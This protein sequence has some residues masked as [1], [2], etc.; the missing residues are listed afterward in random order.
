MLKKITLQVSIFVLLFCTFCK[1][2][3]QSY[4]FAEIGDQVTAYNNAGEFDQTIILL[5]GIIVDRKATAYDRYMAYYL[6]YQTYKRLFVYDKAELNLNLALEEGVKSERKNKVAAQI[7]FEK[8]FMNFDLLKFVEVEQLLL[9]IEEKDFEY[10]SYSTQ[11]FY[12]AVL[13]IMAINKGQLE[14][15]AKNYEIAIHLFETHEPE[16]LPM[17]YRKQIDLYR[18][19]NQHDKA[20]ESFEKGLYYA[21]KYNI[22]VYILNMYFDL[23]HYYKLTGD[24]EKGIQAQEM[25]DKLAKAY[26]ESEVLG[27]LNILESQLMQERIDG[28]QNKQQRITF[29][30]ISSLLFVILLLLF[31]YKYL[32]QVRKNKRQLEEENEQ[33]RRDVLQWMNE[34]EGNQVHMDRLTER[35]HEIIELVKTGKTNKEIGNLLFVSENTVKYHLK[36]I[37]EILRVSSRVEL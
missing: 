33:L 27:K 28:E 15:A 22:D 35:Q 36:N 12:Y 29:I 26:N 11:G 20:I 25:C 16:S 6:K 8:L 24:A 30:L 21:K 2:Y 9:T 4:N 5:E 37:Y 3:S 18:Q 19:L 10:V 7:K 31:L 13:G 23:A 14:E 1:A 34:Y 32:N 17:I